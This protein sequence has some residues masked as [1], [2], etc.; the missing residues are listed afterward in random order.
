MRDEDLIPLLDEQLGR[1]GKADRTAVLLRYYE[2]KSL[3]EVGLELGISEEAAKKRVQRAVE[4][5]ST[6]MTRRQIPLGEE[7]LTAILTDKLVQPAPAKLSA[8]VL[9]HAAHGAAMR[10]ISAGQT[11]L[12]DKL[13][14]RTASGGKIAVGVTG[15]VLAAG[16]AVECVVA[17]LADH[18]QAMPEPQMLATLPSTGPA[19]P[20]PADAGKSPNLTEAQWIALFQAYANKIDTLRVQATDHTWNQWR[21]KANATQPNQPS[22][23]VMTTQT[24]TSME[25]IDWDLRRRRIFSTSFISDD[26]TFVHGIRKEIAFPMEPRI[27]VSRK[28]ACCQANFLLGGGYMNAT[29]ADPNNASYGTLVSGAPGFLGVLSEDWQPLSTPFDPQIPLKVMLREY[30]TVHQRNHADGIIELRFIGKFSKRPYWPPSEFRY[31]LRINGGLR[32]YRESVVDYD[33]HHPFREFLT[34]FSRFQKRDGIWLPMRIRLRVWGYPTNQ[35]LSDQKITVNQIEVHRPFK[36]GTFQIPPWGTGDTDDERYGISYGINY[37][38]HGPYHTAQLLPPA[39]T[40]F[41]RIKGFIMPPEVAKAFI[42]DAHVPITATFRIKSRSD[43]KASFQ[44][45]PKKPGVTVSPQSFTI[46]PGGSQNVNVKMNAPPG[47]RPYYFG[48]SLAGRINL[49]NGRQLSTRIP[50]FFLP[51]PALITKPGSIILS[52]RDFVGQSSYATTLRFLHRLDGSVIV[53][54]VNSDCPAIT[55]PRWSQKRME[56]VVRPV[57]ATRALFAEITVI[58]TYNGRMETMRIPVVGMA[59]K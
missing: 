26:S 43:Q 57:A 2:R 58:Y 37:G 33:H 1:L 52:P 17:V 19:A 8:A 4:K 56:V 34:E 50:V 35:L 41:A 18:K 53:D 22:R 21:A 42:S 46:F 13:S 10:A 3:M 20:V 29:I 55:V 5:L 6:R 16:L 24:S 51:S 30:R 48:L 11:R 15:I 59:H 9:A 31:R 54:L 39:K 45:R 36:K 12:S 28:N 14:L 32:V 23:W 27:T 38:T 25:S 47:D 40:A 49:P 44:L 7:T